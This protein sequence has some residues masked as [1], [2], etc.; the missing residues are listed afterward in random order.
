MSFMHILRLRSRVSSTQQT[1]ALGKKTRAKEFNDYREN[2][3]IA[4]K[5]I[6]YNWDI[7]QFFVSGFTDKVKEFDGNVV[8]LKNVGDKVTLGSI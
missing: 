1:Y 7:G 5:D 2:Q 4:K 6:H 8:F 3:E